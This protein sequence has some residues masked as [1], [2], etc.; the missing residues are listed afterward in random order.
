MFAQI[1]KYLCQTLIDKSYVGISI[2]KNLKVKLKKIFLSKA[3][4]HQ[5]KKVHFFM[6]GDF[7]RNRMHFFFKC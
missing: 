6:I 4:I 7:E 1:L 2:N 3:E 5:R